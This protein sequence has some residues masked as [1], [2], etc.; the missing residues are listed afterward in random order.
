MIRR[1]HTW[2]ERRDRLIPPQEPVLSI[3]PWVVPN[4]TRVDLQVD[5]RTI[6][7]CELCHLVELPSAQKRAS[8]LYELR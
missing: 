3:P 1:L 5:A 8:G 6:W 4:R 7:H 2:W